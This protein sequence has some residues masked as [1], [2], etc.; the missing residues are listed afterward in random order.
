MSLLPILQYPNPVLAQKAEPVTVFDES[1][2]QLAKDMAETMYAAPG[3][4]LAAPQIGRLIRLVVIDVS[5]EKN[6]LKVFVNPTIEVLGEE[7]VCGEEG[8]LSLPDVYDKVERSAHVR[9]KAQDLKG[10][11][12]E[13]E[14]EDVLAVCIQHECDHLEGVVFIDHLSLLKKSRAAM[15]L[16]KKQK[17]KARAKKKERAS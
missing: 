13:L 7:T 2:A 5:D 15:K 12:F 11:P 6:D 16:A 10:E 14:C 17:E 1:L 8:C 3:I 4:G 9:V